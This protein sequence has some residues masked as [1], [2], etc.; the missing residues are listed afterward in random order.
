MR[1]DVSSREDDV[2]NT[3]SCMS[4]H[5]QQVRKITK[6]RPLNGAIPG[7]A[8][9][10]NSSN[11]QGGRVWDFLASEKYDPFARFDAESDPAVDVRFA[12]DFLYS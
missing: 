8:S 2:A 4:D 11:R 3:P 1:Y 5:N 10:L 7:D 9:Y 12:A 6:R